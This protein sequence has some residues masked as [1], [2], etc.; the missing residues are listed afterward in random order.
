[1]LPEEEEEEYG[2]GPVTLARQD[3]AWRANAAATECHA[4]DGH[5]NGRGAERSVAS[6]VIGNIGDAGVTQDAQTFRPTA[7][8][9]HVPA[10]VTRSD[11]PASRLADAMRLAARRVF[12]RH[13]QG[14]DKVEK[15]RRRSCGGDC[16]GR[17]CTAMGALV[18]LDDVEF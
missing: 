14:A 3:R 15:I 12:D 4:A 2:H 5:E 16:A 18:C 13:M 6:A 10:F 1:M 7:T 9:S 8:A 17:W 11:Q